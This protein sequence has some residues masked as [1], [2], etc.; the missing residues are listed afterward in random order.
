MRLD[1]LLQ[2]GVVPHDAGTLPA[3]LE[4]DALILRR[5]PSSL[6]PRSAGPATLPVMAALRT[7]GWRNSAS[8]TLLRCR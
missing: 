5:R 3:E 4:R 8:P 6:P 2:V 7:R 1:R